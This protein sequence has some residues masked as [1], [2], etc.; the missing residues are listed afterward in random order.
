[1]V[2]LG[3][4]AGKHSVSQLSL[5]ALY[6]KGNGVPKDYVQAYMWSDLAAS[7]DENL[8]D[9]AVENRDAAAAQMTPDQIARA[10]K[11]VREGKPKAAE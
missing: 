5:G 11:L 8:H 6:F 3:G 2:R 7:A 10:Q 9:M 1:V 4:R